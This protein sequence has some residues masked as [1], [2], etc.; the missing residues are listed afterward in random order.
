M[1]ATKKN[2][3]FDEVINSFLRIEQHS[4][5]PSAVDLLKDELNDERK[6]L[7]DFGS[8]AMNAQESKMAREVLDLVDELDKFV[9]KADAF[10]VD[11]KN[12]CG[13]L[14]NLKHKF[15]A[16]Q[17][18][19]STIK[20]PQDVSPSKPD[21]KSSRRKKHNNGLVRPICDCP[22]D[23]IPTVGGFFVVGLL[24]LEERGKL[25]DKDVRDLQTKEMK[26]QFGISDTFPIVL[27]VPENYGKDGLFPNPKN[28]EIM[29]YHQ[30]F[31]LEHNDNQYYISTQCFNHHRKEIETFFKKRGL[32]KKEIFNIC[33]A[34]KV[35]KTR[36]VKK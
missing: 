36:S 12:L 30:K 16:G 24:E 34:N 15:F 28:G 5:V 14:D 26:K 35:Q 10:L 31:K 29:R 19:K 8:K 18:V 7:F 27:D 22:K 1:A 3:N 33:Y 25:S 21:I 20:T 6:I 32:T 11:W 13:K 2:I 23:Y 17:E 4:E 9:G